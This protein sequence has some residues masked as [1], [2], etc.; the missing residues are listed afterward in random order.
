MGFRGGERFGMCHE[1]SRILVVDCAKSRMR[2]HEVYQKVRKR[3]K[4]RF[5]D[6]KAVS[7]IVKMYKEQSGFARSQCEVAITDDQQNGFVI[8]SKLCRMTH[9][10]QRGQVTR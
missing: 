8:F 9:S 6:P 4:Q 5:G 7:R 1:T 3:M 2:S 10:R